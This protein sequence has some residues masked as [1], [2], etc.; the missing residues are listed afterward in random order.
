MRFRS[1]CGGVFD[2]SEFVIRCTPSLGFPWIGIT[3]GAKISMDVDEWGF[4]SVIF[5][6]WGYCFNCFAR[7]FVSILIAAASVSHSPAGFR[8]NRTFLL[9]FST[10]LLIRI[11][12]VLES[13]LYLKLLRS[14]SETVIQNVNG[15]IGTVNGYA[16]SLEGYSAIFILLWPSSLYGIRIGRRLW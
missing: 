13:K 7:Y 15:R 12:R 16:D 2:L 1:I 6:S 10:M 4:R 9:D 3:I 11:V 14:L 8:V 5:P